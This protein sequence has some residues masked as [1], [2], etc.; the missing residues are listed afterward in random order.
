MLAWALLPSLLL[1]VLSLLLLPS[2]HSQS[3]TTVNVS[4]TSAAISPPIPSDFLSFSIE[5]DVALEWTGRSRTTPRP[6][7]VAL[8][9]QLGRPTLRI[10]GDSTDYSWWNPMGRPFPPYSSRPFR[11]NITD[12]DVR[13]IV[14]GVSSYGGQVVFGV[15][16]RNQGNAQ[17][18][19]EHMT[20]IEQAVGVNH[21]A[22]LGYEIGNEVDLFP[23]N[24]DRPR[25]W[26][27]REYYTEW[28]YYYARIRE[29]LPHLEQKKL[30][31]AAY[32]WSAQRT[33]EM[34]A[35]PAVA[36]LAQAAPHSPPLCCCADMR[37]TAPACSRM[38]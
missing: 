30:Q 9:R 32:C 23:G 2:V 6:E 12:L 4:F 16:F 24:D 31:A 15:N 13:S 3:C 35:A 14:N 5:V 38:T 19:V 25:D 1:A 10:G 34:A 33:T 17:W 28:E 20:G 21:P 7:F 8:M 11:Y 18:A 22:I 37:C 27:P 26:T 29:A 36:G